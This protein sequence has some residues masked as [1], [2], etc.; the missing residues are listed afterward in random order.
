M[1]DDKF[2]TEACDQAIQWARAVLANENAV[3][4]DTETTGLGYTDQV[5]QVAVIDVHGNTLLDTLVKPTCEFSAEAIAVHQ[6]TPVVV[7]EAPDFLEIFLHLCDVTKGKTVIAYNAAFDSRVLMQSA[8]GDACTDRWECA[9]E[10]YAAY[11]GQWNDYRESFKWQ[12]LPGGDHSALGDALATL[13]LIK[14][15]AGSELS[16]ELAA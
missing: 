2:L 8:G 3:I 15:M 14:R 11:Y 7:A 6:I 5:C 9:M 4:L 10:Q 12:R 13:L 16:T 1:I